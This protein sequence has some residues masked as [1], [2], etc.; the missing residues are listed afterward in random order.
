MNSVRD[1]C[2]FKIGVIPDYILWKKH[3]TVISSGRFLAFV[4]TNFMRSCAKQCLNA[5]LNYSLCRFGFS[6]GIQLEYLWN[7][8]GTSGRVYTLYSIKQ[9]FIC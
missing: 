8:A 4:K 2:S 5:F 1:G 3:P 6:S 7:R 9:L